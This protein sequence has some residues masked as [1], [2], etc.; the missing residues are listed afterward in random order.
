MII[1]L[2]G[3]MGSGKSHIG[4]LLSKQL[5]IP[6]YDLDL[7]IMKQEQM[8]ITNIFK[9][10]GEIYFRKIE[11]EVLNNILKEKENFLLSVGGG[12]P[13]FYNNMDIINKKSISIYLQNSIETLTKRLLI[14]KQ[15]RPVISHLED[16]QLSEFIAKHLFE[17]RNFYEKAKHIIKSDE[18]DIKKTLNIIKEKIHL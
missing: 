12:T 9:I 5:S 8:S 6:F 16:F 10:K 14:E 3:Y 7:L 17:R 15:Y 11:K 2:I 1:T 4:N 18:Q 13:C